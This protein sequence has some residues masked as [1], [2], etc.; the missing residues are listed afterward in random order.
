MA[1]TC[2]NYGHNIE[3]R[4]ENAVGV[5]SLSSFCYNDLLLLAHPTCFVMSESLCV[6]VRVCELEQLVGSSLSST[7]VVTD[8]FVS[9]PSNR[10][11]S[12]V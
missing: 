11:S 1:G 9:R 2:C 3:T 12:H 5:I 6:R 10:R 4:Q 7:S 8:G